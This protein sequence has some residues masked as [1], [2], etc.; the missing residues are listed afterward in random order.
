[1]LPGLACA[2]LC[3]FVLGPIIAAYQRRRKGRIAKR[4]AARRRAVD[5]EQAAYA[6][7][8]A[9]EGDNV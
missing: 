3:Y 7:H 1:M 5:A 8:D 4:A 9:R 2:V 6:I